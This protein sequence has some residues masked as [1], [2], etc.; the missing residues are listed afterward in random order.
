MNLR[1]SAVFCENLR[2]SAK[3]CVLGSL[4]HHSS[5]LLKGALNI[6]VCPT[7]NV[8]GRNDITLLLKVRGNCLAILSGGTERKSQL[9][10]RD[11]DAIRR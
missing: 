9:K 11:S 10:V 2:F 8:F 4:C 1:K 7:C 3:I 6:I 5:V